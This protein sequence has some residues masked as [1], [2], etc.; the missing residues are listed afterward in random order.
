MAEDGVINGLTVSG[1]C[2][3]TAP[4]SKGAGSQAASAALYG[5][6]ALGGVIDVIWLWAELQASQKKRTDPKNCRV[7]GMVQ[8][9]KIHRGITGRNDGSISASVNHARINPPGRRAQRQSEEE[10]L[11]TD[12]KDTALARQKALWKCQRY[13]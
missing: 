4:R 6:V 1:T 9:K 12:V 2:R 13:G 10:G 3:R 11:T 5:T 8:E 7:I